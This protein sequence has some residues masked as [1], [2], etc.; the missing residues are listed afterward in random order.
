VDPVDAIDLDWARRRLVAID[1]ELRVTPRDDFAR[2][3]ALQAAGDTLR[4]VLRNGRADQIAAAR[5]QWNDRAGR[6]GEH[7]IDTEALEGFASRIGTF[8]DRA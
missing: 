6:K 7:E 3:H 1:D 5:A 2:R 8:G 4:A